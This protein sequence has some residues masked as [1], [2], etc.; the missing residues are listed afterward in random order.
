MN[1][2]RI[3]A[4]FIERRKSWDLSGGDFECEMPGHD[5]SVP[6]T[7]MRADGQLACA[8]HEHMPCEITD[9]MLENFE[10]TNAFQREIK[11]L[12]SSRF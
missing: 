10:A 2:A 9:E 1:R 5:K 3:M 6:A 11:T 4:E 7:V 12:F 8:A